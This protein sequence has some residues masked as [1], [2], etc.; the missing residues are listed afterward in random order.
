MW[1]SRLLACGYGPSMTRAP[2]PRSPSKLPAPEQPNL[3]TDPPAVRA[4]RHG[5]R[6]LSMCISME[7]DD[8]L[9]FRLPIDAPPP[10]LLPFDSEP[11]DGMFE[12]ALDLTPGGWRQVAE[13]VKQGAR[14]RYSVHGLQRM[15]RRLH[16]MLL[17]PR[18][19]ARAAAELGV[20][21]E[22]ADG[23]TFRRALRWFQDS[24]P[25]LVGV[26]LPRDAAGRFELFNIRQIE[27]WSFDLVQ[28][29]AALHEAPGV[30]RYGTVRV[31]SLDHWHRI[32]P[33]PRSLPPVRPIFEGRAY[34]Q[35]ESA[36]DAVATRSTAA[37]AAGKTAA[38]DPTKPA[39]VSTA[40]R[41]ANDRA[42]YAAS[43]TERGIDPVKAKA[44]PSFRAEW[45]ELRGR[46]SR[47]RLEAVYGYVWRPQK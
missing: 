2:R 31:L 34:R 9:L 12:L 21:D 1:S 32:Q 42:L 37:S 43:L 8:L 13:G 35:L 38:G 29:T 26:P 25:V 11:G 3:R 15:I 45:K 17:E 44:P 30:L 41:D 16:A 39:P 19:A 7:Q 33:P 36:L 23:E 4:L 10:N 47:Q 18:N 22:V 20:A 24:R 40:E 28:E 14:I 27:L 46:L 5:G 6:A